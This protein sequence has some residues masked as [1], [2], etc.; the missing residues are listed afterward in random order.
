MAY[1]VYC[2][3]SLVLFRKQLEHAKV[4]FRFGFFYIG[5]NPT[6]YYWEFVIIYRK[7]F[8]ICILILNFS[9]LSKAVMVLFINS[10]CFFFHLIQRPFVDHRLNV[11]E[12]LA[13]YVSIITIYGG[14]FYLEDSFGEIF[15]GMVFFVIVLVNILFILT[16]LHTVLLFAV[17]KY[18]DS[19]NNY[20]LI[21]TKVFEL[22]NWML[23]LLGKGKMERNHLIFISNRK[24][25]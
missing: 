23:K 19:K 3:T 7:I 5:Y 6:L 4:K 2:L 17:R 18:K 20:F 1:P 9:I 16:W 13:I 25:K 15:Q 10:F 14:L 11:L 8:T 21:L 22:L 24:E 12:F